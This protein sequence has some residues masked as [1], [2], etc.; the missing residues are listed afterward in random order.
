MAWVR[1]VLVVAVL[2][3][4]QWVPQIPGITKWAPIF[5]PFFISAPSKIAAKFWELATTSGEQGVVLKSGNLFVQLW[6]TV[7]AALIGFVVGVGSGFL[8]GLVLSQM[9]T[10]A[11]IL[12]PYLVAFNALPR[13]ALVPLIIMI[14][15]TGLGAKVVLAWLIVFFIVFFNTYAGGRAIEPAIV[16]S[17]R[18]LGASRRQLLWTVVVPHVAGWTFAVLPLA[19]SA[20]IIGVV[21]G[22]FVGGAQ[23]LGYIITVALGQLEATDLFVALITLCLVA[24]TLIALATRLER[25]L[26]HWRPEHAGREG[27]A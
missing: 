7:R 14:F 6:A 12:H 23:G 25:R 2:A 20:S 11:R 27:T 5:D 15:G 1:L 26:L 10:L 8:S 9:K 4:W 22:E 16:D 3:V 13:I 24:V 19:M 21:V 17:C 18:I